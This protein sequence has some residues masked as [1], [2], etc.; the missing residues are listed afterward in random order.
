MNTLTD[1]WI[2]TYLEEPFWPLTA[3]GC[4]LISDIAHHLALRNR[5]SG[6][7]AKPYSVAQHSVLV[8][9]ELIPLGKDV[10]LMG[11]L[12]DAAE[13]Y[14]PD[15]PRPIKDD[16]F[17]FDGTQMRSFAEVEDA[18]MRRLASQYGLRWPF[19]DAVKDADNRVCATE[20]RDL[21]ASEYDW[22]M[23]DQIEPC[24][25]KVNSWKWKKAKRV[26]HDLFE[27]LTA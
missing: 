15:M 13:A 8:A 27:E 2:Q 7:T 18:I 20:R 9:R 6:A 11:L 24:T 26:F 25:Y 14:L 1:G 4:I 19:P 21:M 10:A 12:H 23:I 22:G 5:F 17:F 16:A 3:N